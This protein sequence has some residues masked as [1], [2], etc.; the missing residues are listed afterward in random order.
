MAGLAGS[1]GVSNLCAA[2]PLSAGAG[3]SPRDA[4]GLGSSSKA[5]LET[6]T[7]PKNLFPSVSLVLISQRFHNY[8]FRIH[9]QA[10]PLFTYWCKINLSSLE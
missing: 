4:V 2:E 9:Q 1:C 10:A 6:N 3:C 5:M 8:R 7:A